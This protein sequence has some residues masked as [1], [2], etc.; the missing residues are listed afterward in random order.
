MAFLSLKERH[1]WTTPFHPL[2][3]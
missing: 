1:H 2:F 3:R